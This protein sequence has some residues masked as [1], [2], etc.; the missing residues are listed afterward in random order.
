[1]EW[2]GLEDFFDLIACFEHDLAVAV[3]GSDAVAAGIEIFFRRNLGVRQL[4][5]KTALRFGGHLN[6]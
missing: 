4:V 5:V 1:M 2:R 3:D 6:W